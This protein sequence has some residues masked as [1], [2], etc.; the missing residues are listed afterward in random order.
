[1]SHCSFRAHV[2]A[3]AAAATILSA[4]G[5]Q[6]SADDDNVPVAKPPV[7]KP[8][9]VEG[10]NDLPPGE[11]GGVLPPAVDPPAGTTAPGGGLIPEADK[12]PAGRATNPEWSRNYCGCGTTTAWYADGSPSGYPLYAA[13]TWTTYYPWSYVNYGAYGGYSTWPYYSTPY[14][15][16]Y[17]PF[18]GYWYGAGYGIGYGYGYPYYS[19]Y[20]AYGPYYTAANFWYAGW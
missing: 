20:P 19:A 14:W 18:A 2:F 3:M 8:A 5:L 15:S 11:P 4:A 16:P 13:P 10:A 1:M 17:Q 12:S 9:L 6:V 7:A